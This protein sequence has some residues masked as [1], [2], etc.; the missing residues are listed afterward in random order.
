MVFFNDLFL[1]WLGGATSLTFLE[2]VWS[3]V[4]VEG[5]PCWRYG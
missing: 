3:R 2:S 4:L 5:L 1:W